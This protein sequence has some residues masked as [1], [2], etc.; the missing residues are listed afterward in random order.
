VN[1]SYVQEIRSSSTL[2]VVYCHAYVSDTGGKACVVYVWC[3]VL[4]ISARSIH[5][6]ERTCVCIVMWIL[7]L[8]SCC[9]VVLNGAWWDNVILNIKSGTKVSWP[10]YGINIIPAGIPAFLSFSNWRCTESCRDPACFNILIIYVIV[11]ICHCS[12]LEICSRW[13]VFYK[14]AISGW[15]ITK[16]I[17]RNV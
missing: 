9:I 10:A 12:L 14:S 1:N 11:G 8:Q 15:M 4:F 6:L 16:Q 3:S 17:R 7:P 13:T 2:H 5:N